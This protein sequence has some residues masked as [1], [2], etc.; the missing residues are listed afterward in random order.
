[1]D[2]LEFHRALMRML[3]HADETGDASLAE[4]LVE[5]AVEE[6]SDDR[7]AVNV[8]IRRIPEQP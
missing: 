2:P 3:K 1:M 8:T 6:W 7:F 4:G 5:R